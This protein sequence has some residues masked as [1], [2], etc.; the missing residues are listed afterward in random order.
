M[1]SVRALSADWTCRSVCVGPNRVKAAWRQ[2]DRRAGDGRPAASCKRGRS[3][4]ILPVSFFLYFHFPFPQGFPFISAESN[5]VF[6]HFL[7]H[8]LL[9]FTQAVG[10][11]FLL[12]SALH[13]SFPPHPTASFLSRF[14]TLSRHGESHLARV[15]PPC[16]YHCECL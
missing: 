13:P 1:T 14:L 6:I 12:S 16:C 3:L 2:S 8:P 11:T 4:Y 9:F 10:T 7:F 5:S 15:L